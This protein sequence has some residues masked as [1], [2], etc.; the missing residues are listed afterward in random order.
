MPSLRVACRR[1]ASERAVDA[2]MPRHGAR[3]G[4]P[5]HAR[6]RRSSAARPTCATTGS[7]PRGHPR[8]RH[9]RDDGHRRA[10]DDA[11]ARRRA[12]AAGL[13]SAAVS[14]DGD[15]ASHDRL[16]GV[17]GSYRSALAALDNLR[18]AG[19]LRDQLA[20]QPPLVARTWPRVGRGFARPRR[21]GSSSSPSRWAARPTSPRCLLQP[22]DLLELFP[23]LAQL[24]ARPTRAYAAHRGQQPGATSG[25][26]R[27]P[28]GATAGARE[29]LRRRAGRHRHR[30]DGT[31]KG[32]PSLA[33]RSW[34][35]GSVRDAPLAEIGSA[36]SRCGTRVT[37][38]WT[39]SGATARPATTPT[40]CRA[41]CTWT[42]TCSLA[43]Q[44]TTPFAT[45]APSRWIARVNA[46]ASCACGQP[47]M[48]PSTKG[49]SS[50]SSKTCPAPFARFRSSTVHVG[51]L[52]A[53]GASMQ[54]LQTCPSCSRHI[55]VDEAA[56]P[57]CGAPTPEG[58][59]STARRPVPF[60]APLSR[61]AILFLGAA[62]ACGSS[63]PKYGPA[64]V[65]DYDSGPEE[66]RLRGLER[67][68]RPRRQRRP[69]LRL[70]GQRGGR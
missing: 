25:P 58:F 7:N 45:T 31:I 26:M 46:S 2:G 21:A 64:F 1:R 24:K 29:R 20:D 61:A 4:G 35:G 27:A 16:R 32:C 41:G 17:Q 56:C 60:S 50:C 36:P 47:P 5:R 49:S 28:T 12:K 63:S 67:A 43:A 70:A 18:A 33:T 69:R 44:A 37:A 30:S 6:G 22:Y 9:A 68:R 38:R 57:F 51:I 53:R 52:F 34:S 59:A 40:P 55:K 42:G 15:E 3:P 48:S 8:S 39:T 23:L 66:R 54:P 13:F 10:W 14:I 11:R 62:S 65:Y 19:F